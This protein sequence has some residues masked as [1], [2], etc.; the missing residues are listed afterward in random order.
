[1]GAYFRLGQH[2]QGIEIKVNTPNPSP[3]PSPGPRS[4]TDPIPPLTSCLARTLALAL[5]YKGNHL[6]GD[7][8]DRDAAPYPYLYPYL[9][10]YP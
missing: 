6:L 4:S 2:P 7:A 8:G 9:Y 5:T 3:D 10:S 1:M